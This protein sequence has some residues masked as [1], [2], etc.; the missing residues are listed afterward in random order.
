MSHTKTGAD[1]LDAL[2]DA[3]G[4]TDQDIAK[5]AIKSNIANTIAS[6]RINAGLSQSELA[7]K[8]G[9][10]QSTIS[11]WESGEVNFTIDLL[12]DIAADLNL[13]LDIRLKKATPKETYS[14]PNT[15]YRGDT[16]IYDFPLYRGLQE[17]LKEM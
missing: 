5:T 8:I 17:E 11:K 16:K 7:T 6:A 1:L 15:Y 14:R 9:K 13:D 10:T 4:L 3:F 2:I 12:V